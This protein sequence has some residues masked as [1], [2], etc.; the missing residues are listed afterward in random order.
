MKLLRFGTDR[1]ICDLFNMLFCNDMLFDFFWIRGFFVLAYG[2]PP[3]WACF[4]ALN[5]LNKFHLNPSW[6]SSMYCT[7]KTCRATE[8]ARQLIYPDST[9]L[10]KLPLVTINIGQSPFNMQKKHY[11]ICRLWYV[12]SWVLI[13]SIFKSAILSVITITKQFVITCQSLSSWLPINPAHESLV[14]SF[15]E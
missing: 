1:D 6:I 14:E 4:L 15:N 13:S 2:L 9:S 3:A 5:N 7:K 8:T 10:I 11:I 12:V